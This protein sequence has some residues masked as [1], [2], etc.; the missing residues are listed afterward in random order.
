MSHLRGIRPISDRRAQRF[1]IPGGESGLGASA[2]ALVC[3]ADQLEDDDRNVS[4]ECNRSASVFCNHQRMIRTMGY[5]AAMKPGISPK[6][7][8]I[9]HPESWRELITTLASAKLASN[10]SGT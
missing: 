7:A 9:G 4:P 6:S 8:S 1:P 2:V 3:M 5:R 10:C